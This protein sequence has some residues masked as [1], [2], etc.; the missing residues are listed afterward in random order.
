MSEDTRRV[1]RIGDK[2]SLTKEIMQKDIEDFAELTMDSN[3]IHLDPVLSGRGLFRRPVAHGVFVGSLI[4]SVMGTELP[5]PGTVLRDQEI[6][7]LNPV[8][9][10]DIITAEV[11]LTE[12]EEE[13]KY[14][15]ATLEGTCRNQDQITVVKATSHQLMLKRFFEV[16]K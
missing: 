1:C 16:K 10:G 12:I 5:G 9:P 14:Y 13:G 8:Y 3:G 15:V 6:Q 11:I 4:S 2:A 7:Y